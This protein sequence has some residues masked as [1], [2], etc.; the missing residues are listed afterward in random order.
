MTA[1]VIR[2]WHLAGQHVCSCRWPTPRPIG[3]FSVE[4]CT[5]C[6]GVVMPL[7]AAAELIERLGR[8]GALA[9]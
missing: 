9:P 5:A 2:A 7:D 6:S 4:E 3:V 1:D 8:A